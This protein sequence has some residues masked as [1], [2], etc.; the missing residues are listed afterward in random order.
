M[1]VKRM[2]WV[3]GAV[4]KKDQK[5]RKLYERVKNTVR[6]FVYVSIVISKS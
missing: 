1:A 2:R 3:W 5:M 6:Q 4:D